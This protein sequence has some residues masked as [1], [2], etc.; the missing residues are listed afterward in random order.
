MHGTPEWELGS[1]LPQPL[2]G[3]VAVALEH[4]YRLGEAHLT[5]T[6]VWLEPS[7]GEVSSRGEELSWLPYPIGFWGWKSRGR[8][9]QLRAGSG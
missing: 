7:T 4:M 2:S 1:L 5:L 8:Q 9:S 6:T 3:S